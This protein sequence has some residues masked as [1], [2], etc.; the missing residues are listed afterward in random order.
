MR[1]RICIIKLGALGDVLRTM[2]IA[3]ALERNNPGAEITWITKPEC[4]DLLEGF[5]F[6]DKI[7]SVPY[8]GSKIFDVLYNFDIENEATVLANSIVAKRRY[9]FANKGGYP[10][11]LNLGAEYYLNTVFDD[12]LKRKNRK[13]YQVMMFEAAEMKFNGEHAKMALSKEDEEYAND[14]IKISGINT[15][16]LIGIHMGA[17]SRWPSKVWHESRIKEFI[18]K[19]RDKGYEILL[20]GGPNE[21]KKQE[22]MVDELKSKGI[23]IFLNNPKN[24]HKEFAALVEKCKVIVCSDS[25]AL[26]VAVSMK[27]PT[28]ALFFCT[29]PWEI[30]NYSFLREVTS[31]LLEEFFPHRSDEYNEELTKSISVEKVLKEVEDMARKTNKKAD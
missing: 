31:P 7:E 9:G 26:H 24:T 19:A 5:E 23:K 4:K 13:T 28:V 17:S 14:F 10:V 6:V 11:A 25:F 1:T 18:I 22:K 12:E 2:P 27:K 20:F 30:E 29:S 21:A 15:K 16:K 3:I 8:K